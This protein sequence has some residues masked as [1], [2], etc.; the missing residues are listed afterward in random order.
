L[1]CATV[2]EPIAT[3]FIIA[4]FLFAWRRMYSHFPLNGLNYS[5]D[6]M[7][8]MK[9]YTTALLGNVHKRV[10]VEIT[11]SCHCWSRLPV[12]GESIPPNRFVA[13][14]SEQN[15]RNRIFC[16]ERHELSRSLPGA[17]EKMLLHNG[18]VRVNYL[19]RLASIILAGEARRR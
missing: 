7:N 14:G 10:A 5:L 2:D 9:S 18:L 16:E 6:H 8:V 1:K 15:P 3:C 12:E 11:Y 19:G 17:M 13:D 4:S